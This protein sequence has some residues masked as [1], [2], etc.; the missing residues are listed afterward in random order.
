MKVCVYGA[1]AIGG[2]LAVRLARAG[3][4][5]S[6]VAVGR[7]LQAIRDNGIQI[8]SHGEGVS[9]DITVSDDTTSLGP[10]D[11]VIIAVKGPALHSIAPH[12]PP[13]LGPNTVVMTAMNGVPWWFFHGHGGELAERSL[14]SV[15]PDGIIGANIPVERVV[16]CIVKLSCRLR[17][18]GQVEH[19]GGNALTIGEPDNSNSPRVRAL[20]ERLSAAGFQ[21]D[22]TLSLQQEIWLKLLGN[23]THNP[24]SALTGATLDRILD[25]PLAREFTVKIMRE[26]IAVGQKLGYTCDQTPE[27]RNAEARTLGAFKTSMLQDVEAGKAIE[28]DSL[29]VAFK[30]IATMVRVETPFADALLGLARVKA[31]V[32]GLYP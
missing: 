32:L 7:T 10:Q 2:L 18:P 11:L 3:N 27:N 15:D 23:M 25:D 9:A 31:Q 28:L 20:G 8:Y 14:R 21:V 13:L 16:G 19:V 24:I 26:A 1:G 17:Q 29:M 22:V 4:Q 6:V 30:E 5:V 12:L